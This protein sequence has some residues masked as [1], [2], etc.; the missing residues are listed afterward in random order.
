[1]HINANGDVEPCAFIHYSNV[2][3]KDVDL[4]DALRSPLFMEYKKHQPFNQ[5]HLRP[6]PMLDN[7]ELI[8]EMVN[9]AGAHSTQLEDSESV[10]ELTAK[11]EPAAAKWEPVAEKLWTASPK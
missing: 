6:C 3:I 4:I 2:N 11:T 1:M 7:P 5:N 10:E 9:K 8:R